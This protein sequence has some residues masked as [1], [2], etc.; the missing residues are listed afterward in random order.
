MKVVGVRGAE[1]GNLA[2]APAPM[3]W[4]GASACARRRRFR[5]R[6]GRAPRAWPGR[7][8]AAAC[9][10]RCLPS[11]SVITM[12]AGVIFS[13]GTPLG[14]ITHRPCS[15]ETRAGIA[16]R[17][18]HQAAANQFEIGFQDF[19]SQRFQ[20]S[21]LPW[22]AP[23]CAAVPA[24]R[25]RSP[26]RATSAAQ[27]RN[28]ACDKARYNSWLVGRWHAARARSSCKPGHSASCASSMVRNAPAAR[29]AKIAEPEAGDI[30]LR[31]PESACPSRW[32][33]PG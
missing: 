33:T 9:L 30:A 12:S 20:H 16:E 26:R 14:L 15:R 19:S 23:R 4:R 10:P 3:R 8:T 5:G 27:M 25:R 32:R 1:A 17:E 2:I 24:A 31:A 21:S 7:T 13:Y 6:R 11:R 18:D 28:T 29:N 22:R